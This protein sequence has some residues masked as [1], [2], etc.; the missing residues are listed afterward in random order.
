M[1]HRLLPVLILIASVAGASPVAMQ[2]THS[3]YLLDGDDQSVTNASASMVFRLY[4]VATPGQAGETLVWQSSVC[5]V[6]S[7]NG[8]YSVDLGGACNGTPA[9]STAHL[10]ADAVRW[11][12][13][14]VGALRL[15]PR[16]GIAPLPSAVTA[17]I[18]SGVAIPG[19]AAPGLALV[20]DAGGVGSWAL[21]GSAAI[22]DGAITDA[23]IAPGAAIAVTK[24]SGLGSLATKTTI[25]DADVAAN[26]AIDSTKISGLGS[27]AAKSSIVHAD[28][29]AGAN[30]A[31]SKISGLGSAATTTGASATAAQGALAA[32]ALPK[33]GGTLTGA[34]TFSGS[35]SWNASGHVG[36]GTTSPAG[37]LEVRDNSRSHFVGRTI[38]GYSNTRDALGPDYI[39]LHQ[40]YEGV[41]LTEHRVMG[42]ITAIRGGPTSWNRKLT[43]EV[44]TA[45]PY[46]QN[47]GSLISHNEPS[48]LVT[49]T[50]GGVKYLAVNGSARRGRQ[51]HASAVA[52]VASVT[53]AQAL[54]AKLPVRCSEPAV[55]S[56]VPVALVFSS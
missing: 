22:A 48:R 20:S 43:A 21:L 8:Y 37:I 31:S 51:W 4:D 49:L 36:I 6:A 27:L 30:I 14:T 7:T 56:N 28:V 44:H 52:T 45:S 42:K 1:F 41:L 9:L 23:D 54:A 53:P 12:E 13:V 33:S 24:L 5:A 39:L 38:G 55:S 11:L 26:A 32:A 34:V 40:A 16:I 10:P 18:A 29:S 3:G 50:S 17:A 46:D 2:I 35:G 15:L 47:R 25:V 19:G